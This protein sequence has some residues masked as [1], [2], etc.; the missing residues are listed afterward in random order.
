MLQGFAADFV[1]NINVKLGMIC[2]NNGRMG[3]LPEL[4]GH[5]CGHDRAVGVQNGNIFSFQ[6]VGN[7]QRKRHPGRIT[8]KFQSRNAGIANDGIGEAFIVCVLICGRN[9]NGIFSLLKQICGIIDNSV[10]N[11]VNQWGEGVIQK[12]YGL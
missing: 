1:G 2:K 3:N 9:N 5:Q 12:T 7:L 4:P 6:T 10:G 8:V 11:T